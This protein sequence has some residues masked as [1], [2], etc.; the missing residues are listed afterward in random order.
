MADGLVEQVLESLDAIYRTEA[1]RIRAT[2]ICLL[3]DFDL[4]EDAVHDAFAAALERC[5][6]APDKEWGPY[7]PHLPGGKE[8]TIRSP[9]LMK[10]A[11]DLEEVRGV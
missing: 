8:A 5:P 9:L 3:G 7:C 4:A 11:P 10:N 2:F 6:Q 1:G